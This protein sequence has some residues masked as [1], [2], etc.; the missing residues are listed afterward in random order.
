M[1]TQCYCD[2]RV[3]DVHYIIK[4]SNTRFIVMLCKLFFYLKIYISRYNLLKLE[5]G[6]FNIGNRDK[7]DLEKI[8]IWDIF[9]LG[10]Q[11]FQESIEFTYCIVSPSSTADLK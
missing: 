7:S 9:P 3:K 2:L 8:G 6:D 1:L 5:M 4:A 11:F 10:F